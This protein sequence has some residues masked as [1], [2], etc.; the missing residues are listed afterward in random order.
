VGLITCDTY[1]IAAVDQLRTYAGII[2]LQ[3]EVVLSPADMQQAVDAL[4]DHDVILIDTA[5]EVR[6]IRTDLE[7]KEFLDVAR[8]HEFTSC[9]QAR[10]PK[11]SHARKRKHSAPWAFTRSP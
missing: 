9:F 1:R 2:G 3:L 7:L 8:P 4:K 6:T 11:S 10:R 5:A